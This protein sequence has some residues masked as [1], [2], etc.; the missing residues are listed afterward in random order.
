MAIPV[1]LGDDVDDCDDVIGVTLS[2][3]DVTV[4]SVLLRVHQR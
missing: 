3:K 2:M 4:F 1:P